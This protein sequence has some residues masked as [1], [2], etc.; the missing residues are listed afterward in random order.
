LF[1]IS[2]DFPKSNCLV[3]LIGFGAAVRNVLQNT[4]VNQSISGFG[5]PSIAVTKIK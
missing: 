5:L 2:W 1:Y 3:S 4:D